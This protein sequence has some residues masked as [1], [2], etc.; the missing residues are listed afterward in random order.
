MSYVYVLTNSSNGVLYIGVT[1][2]LARRV[3]EHREELIDGFT[4]KYHVHKLIYYEQY[5]DITYAI[6]REKQLKKWNHSWKVDLINSK[7]PSWKDL[8][9]DICF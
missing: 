1:N 2:N 4:K 7:N 8:Y 5:D 3:W 6:T 9:P